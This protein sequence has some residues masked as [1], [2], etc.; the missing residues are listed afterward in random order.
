MNRWS[1]SRWRTHGRKSTSGRASALPR[2]LIRRHPCRSKITSVGLET[3]LSLDP[4]HDGKAEKR[5]HRK[6]VS[7][8]RVE[9]TVSGF[10]YTGRL[11]YILKDPVHLRFDLPKFQEPPPGTSLHATNHGWRDNLGVVELTNKKRRTKINCSLNTPC[12]HV[13]AHRRKSQDNNV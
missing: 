6:W 8:Q 11:L 7:F 12:H 1:N 10:P 2:N 13:I 3:P 4:L 5:R 9:W